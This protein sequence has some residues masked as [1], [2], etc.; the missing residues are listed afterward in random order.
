MVLFPPL[1]SSEKDLYLYFSMVIIFRPSF[2]PSFALGEALPLRVQ[3]QLIVRSHFATTSHWP[4]TFVR[5]ACSAL[6][7]CSLCGFVYEQVYMQRNKEES[8]METKTRRQPRPRFSQRP[9]IRSFRDLMLCFSRQVPSCI[10]DLTQR[11]IPYCSS[12]VPMWVSSRLSRSNPLWF[13]ER[14]PFMPGASFLHFE[15]AIEQLE[16]KLIIPRKGSTT[17]FLASDT[18]RRQSFGNL[19]EQDGLNASFSSVF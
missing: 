1:H 15:F 9:V 16:I 2:S 10:S 3:W 13:R 12:I 7:P 8:K 6:A 4:L 11:S 19:Q 14:Q 5:D 17:S 18:I